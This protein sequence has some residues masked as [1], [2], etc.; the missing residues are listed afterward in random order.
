MCSLLDR[1]QV[2]DVEGLFHP[3]EC[4]TGFSRTQALQRAIRYRT[5]YAVAWCTHGRT[6]LPEYRYRRLFLYAAEGYAQDSEPCPAGAFSWQSHLPRLSWDAT[7]AGCSVRE[8]RRT[9]YIGADG[10][11]CRGDVGIFRGATAIG[12]RSTY[13][14]TGNKFSNYLSK[15]LGTL[16]F[17]LSISYSVTISLFKSGWVSK[18]FIHPIN[19]S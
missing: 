7:Q 8:N 5:R 14:Q 4:A 9:E 18:K 6:R 15:I 2:A 19:V 12:R 10:S 16:Q 17:Y 3:K 13:K 11:D 1:G